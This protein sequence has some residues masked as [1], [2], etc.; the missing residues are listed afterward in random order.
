MRPT[1]LSNAQLQRGHNIAKKVL[2]QFDL[3]PALLDVF[4]KKQRINITGSSY[5]PP[6][7]RA[8]KE[9]TVPKQYV[10]KINEELYKFMKTNYWGDPE[11]KLSYMELATN[12]LAF[13]SMVNIYSSTDGLL[14]NDTQKETAR[15]I[16]EKYDQL[17]MMQEKGFDKVL[18]YLKYLTRSLSQVNFRLYGFRYTWE[19]LEPKM[20]S[21]FPSLR[22]KIELTA[23]ECESKVFTYYN[24]ERKAFRLFITEQGFTEP[25]WAIVRRNKIFPKAKKNE[26]LNI[27]IQSHALYRFKERIDILEP[28][29]RN[30]LIQ[31]ALTNAQHVVK[32]E[33]E[34]LLACLI[35]GKHPAGYFTFFIQGHDIVINTFL[36][37]ASD[38]TPEGKK[39]H[40]LLKLSR[41]DILYL[42]MDR[43][44]FYAK[45]D[46]D[47]IP[48][49]KQAL[50]DSDI[51]PLKLVID[52]MADEEQV[53]QGVSAID[54]QKTMFVKNFFDKFEAYHREEG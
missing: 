32:T 53:K 46:F 24:I 21:V 31:Y 35:D 16:C 52:E 49:L 54:M 30:F 15:R 25:S 28:P 7:V 45:V 48:L 13:L 29:D 6:V 40:A 14:A 42:G 20:Y 47:R 9:K 12:G 4:T 51:W 10:K 23:R 3:D 50:I 38:N 37:L 11:G 2:R 17:G 33:K 1:L 22:M 26:E 44:S 19:Y 43:I 36:Y 34:T 27:Y 8:I 5:D 41:E 18:Q 39:L